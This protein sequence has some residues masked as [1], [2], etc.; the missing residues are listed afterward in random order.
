MTYNRKRNGPTQR[1]KM[2]VS[3]VKL[4]YGKRPTIIYIDEEEYLEKTNRD[5]PSVTV[6]H[7]TANGN[8]YVGQ[9]RYKSS[10]NGVVT[11]RRL[12]FWS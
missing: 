8:F 5:M 10:Y 1:P 11:L 4:A 2:N 9:Y 12:A 6:Y 3:F 7:N